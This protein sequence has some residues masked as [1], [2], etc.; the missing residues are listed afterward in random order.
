[1]GKLYV[2]VLLS[3]YQIL[4]LKLDQPLFMEGLIFSKTFKF[5]MYT[6]MPL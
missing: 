3:I 5:V 6:G 4:C 2:Q 1:M